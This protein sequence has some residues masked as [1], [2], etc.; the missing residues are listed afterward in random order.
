[1]N[2]MIVIGQK[3]SA[4]HGTPNMRKQRVMFADRC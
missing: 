2:K 3:P 1:M 4:V